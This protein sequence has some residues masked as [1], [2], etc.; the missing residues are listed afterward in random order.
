MSAALKLQTSIQTVEIDVQLVARD[1]L[2]LRLEVD[3]DGEILTAALTGSGCTEL[4]HL[5]D[6]TR[7]ALKGALDSVPLPSGTG[8]AAMLIRELLLK[9]Q[10]K[11]NFPYQ[12]EELCH[13][14]GIATHKVDDA[15]LSGCHDL[16]SI[17]RA[18]SANTSCGTCRWDIDS[19][20]KYRLGSKP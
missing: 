20:L 17:R 6:E 19:I 3:S 7:R 4:L 15:I 2:S 18:T 16:E 13:C 5:M 10:G 12:E 8:H 1:R 11:W 14:R 9:A